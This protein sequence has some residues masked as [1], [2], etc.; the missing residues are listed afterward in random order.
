LVDQIEETFENAK[1][2]L[3]EAFIKRNRPDYAYELELEMDN[4]K[5]PL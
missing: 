5:T 4:R 3:K 1:K 2:T